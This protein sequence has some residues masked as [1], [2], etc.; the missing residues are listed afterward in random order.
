MMK[1]IQFILGACIIFS[2]Q[3]MAVPA[4]KANPAG[5]E[6]IQA[7][8]ELVKAVDAALAGVKAESPS[9]HEDALRVWK[10][11]KP[12]AKPPNVTYQYWGIRLILWLKDEKKMDFEGEKSD[13]KVREVFTVLWQQK[14]ISKEAVDVLTFYSWAHLLSLH[15]LPQQTRVKESSS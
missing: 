10:H 3:L 15:G 9:V 11:Y 2:S 5:Q 7:D 6:E 13:K 1:R 4:Q 14:L 8:P 12:K